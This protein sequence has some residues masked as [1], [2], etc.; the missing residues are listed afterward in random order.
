MEKPRNNLVF[1]TPE[2]Y[3]KVITQ[4]QSQIRTLQDHIKELK[5]YETLLYNECHQ[6][7]EICHE[8]ITKGRVTY[9]YGTTMC[10]NCNDS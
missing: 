3:V 2:Q 10:G 5:I 1:E 8:C 9:V 6:R 7:F 4:T